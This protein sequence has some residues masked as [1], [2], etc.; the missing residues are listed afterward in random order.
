MARIFKKSGT[1]YFIGIRYSGASKDL[2]SL[3]MT[4]KG[5]GE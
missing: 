5:K 1:W 4:A 2:Y 3:L